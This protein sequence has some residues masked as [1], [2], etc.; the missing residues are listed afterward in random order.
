MSQNDSFIRRWSSRKRRALQ[1]H[2]PTDVDAAKELESDTSS[3][4]PETV[5]ASVDPA[6]EIASVPLDFGIESVGSPDDLSQTLPIA[7]D[8]SSINE[9]NAETAALDEDETLEP[10]LT[11]DDM[12]PISTL[13]DRSD[14]T[15]FFNRG[16]SAKLRRSALRHVFQLPSYNVR[17]GLN[18]YDDDFT[19]FEPLGDIVTSDMKFHA[20][21]KER[22]RLER[23][24]SEEE[25]RLAA[26][27]DQLENEQETP[28]SESES[29]EAN[30]SET[31]EQTEGAADISPEVGDTATDTGSDVEVDVDTNEMDQHAS[32][33][34]DEGISQLTSV[35]K[36]DALQS[37]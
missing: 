31:T 7:D 16:V 10:L 25:A 6:A 34:D 1:D 19:N 35:D 30:T 22:E 23:E 5:I 8:R 13:S 24:K 26:Q 37:S 33:S 32:N 21:R 15:G 28:T 4:A 17:D 18:D 20:A 36:K 14:L 3:R 2:E 9:A 29:D 12:P 27:E 11:D